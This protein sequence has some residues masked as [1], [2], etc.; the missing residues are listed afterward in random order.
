MKTILFVCSGNIFR[1]MCAELLLKKHLSKT[2]LKIKVSSAG[3]TARKQE[4]HKIVKK[5]LDKLEIDYSKHKQRKLTQKIV[6]SSTLIIVMTKKHKDFIKK[7]FATNSILFNDISFNKKEDF[8]D[9]PDIL[10]KTNSKKKTES[11][12]VKAIKELN[13]GTKNILL[14][15]QFQKLQI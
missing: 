10:K 5:E 9:Y 2:N 15:K 13:K 3:T 14:S 12:L 1:S 8:L 11:Y 7:E 6:D 4:I